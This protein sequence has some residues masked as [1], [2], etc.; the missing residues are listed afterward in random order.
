MTLSPEERARELIFALEATTSNDVITSARQRALIATAIRE[1]YA[2]GLREGLKQSKGGESVDF[3]AANF[4][5]LSGGAVGSPG[6]QF[7]LLSKPKD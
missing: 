1:A 2:D 7:T 4:H 3:S 6:D 5:N